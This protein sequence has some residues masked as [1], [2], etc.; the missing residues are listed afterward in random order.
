VGGIDP[1]EGKVTVVAVQVGGGRQRTLSVSP[2]NQAKMMNLRGVTAKSR[3]AM[4]D[5]IV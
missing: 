1:E 4:S 2:V 5:G 3:Q